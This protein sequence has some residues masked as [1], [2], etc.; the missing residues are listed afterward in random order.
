M[1]VAPQVQRLI[2]ASEQ[3]CMRALDEIVM[4]VLVTCR[5]YVL[6][7]MKDGWAQGGQV[8]GAPDLPS[9]VQVFFAILAI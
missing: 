5:I 9:F 8:F 3:I 7:L 6:Q 4:R 2:L 1:D